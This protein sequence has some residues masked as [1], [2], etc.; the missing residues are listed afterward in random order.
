MH[1]EV[2]LAPKDDHE[3]RGADE[4]EPEGSRDAVGR[5]QEPAERRPDHQ[6]ADER[7]VVDAGHPAEHRV[8]DGALA[9]DRRRRAPHEGVGAEDAHRQERDGG[10]G[11]QGEHE[12]SQ[13]LDDQADPHDVGEAEAPLEGPVR[14]RADDAA[15]GDRRR[16]EPEP[17]GVHAEPL[18][19]VEH[20]D[21]ERRAIGD[22]EREDR[23]GER[24]HRG[25][26]HEPAQPLAHLRDEARP[27]P[28]C[29]DGRLA[30]RDAH[31]QQRA[32]REARRVRGE[33]E[34]H[35][36]DEQEGAHRR[37][38]ELVREDVRALQPRVGRPEVLALYEVRD[39]RAPRGIGEGLGGAHREQR[40]EH[41]RDLD[42]TGGDRDGEDGQDD[43]PDDVDRGHHPASVEAVRR[44]TGHDP[45]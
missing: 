32:E 3:Q 24:P 25:V 27:L 34:G 10:R 6:A 13:R 8:G 30:R 20:Q 37:A 29:L 4:P 16:Q 1:D 35:A 14:G 17:E 21:R 26:A 18:R 40:H 9:D 43:R 39:Q 7:D 28:R 41:D 31:D 44:R 5:C 22:V 33:R 23:Q 15:D 45:E 11:R 2:E 42:G 12:V 36:D 19:G 38:D